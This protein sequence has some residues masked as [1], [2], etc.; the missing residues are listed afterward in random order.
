[1]SVE[2][3]T[4]RVP[5]LDKYLEEKPTYGYWSEELDSILYTYYKEFSKRAELSKLVSFLSEKVGF[6]I[7]K[8]SVIKRAE[9]LGLT[10]PRK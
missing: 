8:N 7:P 2:I 3:R 5:E 6:P 9:K 4:V 10:T 1:M